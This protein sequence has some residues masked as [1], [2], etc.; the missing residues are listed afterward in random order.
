MIRGAVRGVCIRG[1][2]VT[3]EVEAITGAIWGRAL[4]EPPRCYG[5]L[6]DAEQYGPETPHKQAT[7]KGK[8]K[9]RPKAEALRRS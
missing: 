8:K 1:G 7:P 6:V 5:V 9:S 3:R 2:V 4:V